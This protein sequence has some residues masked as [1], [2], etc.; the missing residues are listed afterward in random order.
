MTLPF[1]VEVAPMVGT[2]LEIEVQPAAPAEIWIVAGPSNPAYVQELIRLLSLSC[3]DR[4]KTDITIRVFQSGGRPSAVWREVSALNDAP[5]YAGTYFGPLLTEMERRR[6]SLLPDWVALVFVGDPPLDTHAYVDV[7][8]KAPGLHLFH[9]HES[10]SEALR[11]GIYIHAQESIEIVLTELQDALF[12]G[13]R[14]GEIYEEL[15]LTASL[16]DES[17]GPDQFG[18]EAEDEKSLAR[19]V[20]LPSFEQPAMVSA[21]ISNGISQPSALILRGRTKDWEFQALS[22]VVQAVDGLVF[23]WKGFGDPEGVDS[24]Y[25]REWGP[26]TQPLDTHIALRRK[27]ERFGPKFLEGELVLPQLGRVRLGAPLRMAVLPV[28]WGTAAEWV[29]SGRYDDKSLWV[30]GGFEERAE[31][32]EFLRRIANGVFRELQFVT[33]LTWFEASALA[34][35]LGGRLMS[36]EEWAYCVTRREPGAFERVR[37]ALGDENLRYLGMTTAEDYGDRLLGRALKSPLS[38]ALDLLPDHT[39]QRS[40][41]RALVGHLSEQG[42]AFE[43]GPQPL[44]S[45]GLPPHGYSSHVGVRVVFD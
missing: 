34:N 2:T 8:R 36:S 40:S 43:A 11:G 4:S 42:A 18:P 38:W 3:E 9:I 12:Q 35:F 37:A 21:E 29:Y 33:N 19:W 28:L 10:S 25:H 26:K 22:R 23:C 30:E 41:W 27:I 15:F 16:L 7:L 31:P 17:A 5:V 6:K 1:T 13:G 39:G 32:Y 45:F 14:W 24:R 44:G 20:D